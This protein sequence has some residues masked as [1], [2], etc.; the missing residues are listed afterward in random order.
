[1]RPLF[2]AALICVNTVLMNFIIHVTSNKRTTHFAGQCPQP[3]FLPSIP[4]SASSKHCVSSHHC[5][6][7]E[8]SVTQ[9]AH[10]LTVI[11][12]LNWC[13]YPLT[14]TVKLQQPESKLNWSST[15]QDGEKTKLAVTPSMFSGGLPVSDSSLFV[16]VGLKMI[17]GNL[18]N[19]TV[20][21]YDNL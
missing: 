1:M 13:Q 8:C 15:L 5:S 6:K 9:G 3:D 12:K 17:E 10:K 16:Q 21:A 4:A 20:R 19:Y 14:A 7:A 11:L 2:E 18:L